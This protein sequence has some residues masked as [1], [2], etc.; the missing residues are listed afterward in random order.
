MKPTIWPHIKDLRLADDD[1]FT[2]RA[3]DII[4][5]AD[6]YVII[7]KSNIIHGDPHTPIAQLS[8]FGWRII[9]PVHSSSPSTGLS[10][11]VSTQPSVDHL[12]ELLI[13][14]WVQEE[15]RSSIG[16]TLSQDEEE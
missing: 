7:I 8:I 3:I 5:G 9:G 15:P 16:L 10:H 12:Q 14:V 6:Y 13:K 4:I 1:V 2:P 11:H